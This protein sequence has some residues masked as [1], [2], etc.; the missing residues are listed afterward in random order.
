MSATLYSLGEHL[1]AS[2][3]AGSLFA[4]LAA[5]ALGVFVGFTPCVYPILPITVACIG[6][7][8]RGS[9]LNGFIYSLVYVLGMAIVYSTIGVITAITGGQIGRIWN[10]GWVLLALANFFM[11]LALWQLKVI[12][13]SV[14]QIIQGAG[15][16]RRGAL[17]ALL[18]GGASGLVVGPCTLPGLA[19]MV[20]LIGAHAR[21]GSAGSLIFG[22]AAMF[23]YSLGLGSL[24]IVCGT[25]SGILTNLPRSGAWLNAIEKAF[26]ILLIVVAECF[27]I[28]LGQNAKF[29][30]LSSLGAPNTPA[31]A[32]TSAAPAAPRAGGGA[33]VGSP[34]PGWR[35]NDLE[36]N[37]VALGDY[38][39]KKGVLMAFFA[40]WCAAC[41]EEVPS[42][43]A[44][45]SR[46]TDRP[47]ELIGVDNDQPARV[48]KRFAEARK[49][50]YKLVLDPDGTVAAAYGVVG[51]PTFVG[52]D[53]A[54]TIRYVGNVLPGDLDALVRQL[55]TGGP[56]EAR[57]P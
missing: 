8:A 17:G 28:Y 25:F 14:P 31:A 4:I 15:P 19:A 33:S 7:I 44:F 27:L 57:Q 1:S 16:R 52:I 55:E 5:F 35:L 3:Q 54:G 32:G 13:I 2:L 48:V 37:P 24:A 45:Q 53:A 47:V 39:G 21:G 56:A 20:T 41:M 18:V 10:N 23:A 42:L 38:R 43:I 46:Y 26:A 36:G 12:R 29:P 51:F 34:A 22:A 50:N 6:S 11:L 30:L 49:V 40:T 9:K